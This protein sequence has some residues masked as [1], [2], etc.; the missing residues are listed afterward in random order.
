MKAFELESFGT[1]NL[2]L[3][4]RP[5]PEPGPQEVRVRMRA[6]SL[7]FRDLLMVRGHYNPRQPLPLVPLSDGV[8]LVE[9]VGEEVTRVAIGDRVAGIFAQTWLHAPPSHDHV[10]STLGGPLD[11]M[12]AEQVVLHQDGL[13]SLPDHLSDLEAATLP[14]AGVTAWNSLRGEGSISKGDTVLILGTGGVSIF[15]LLFARSLGA[16]T[17]VTSSSDA[18]LERAVELGASETINYKKIEQWW[19][20]VRELTNGQGVDHV[21]EVGGAGTFDQS[22][23]ATKTGGHVSLIG[24]LA[25]GAQKLDVTRILMNNIRVQGVLVGCRDVFEAMNKYVAT[26]ELHPV[27]DRVFPFAEL[28]KALDELGA[29]RHFGKIAIEFP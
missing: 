25:G 27:I 9:A 2:T 5:T 6:A 17:I 29:G 20:R 1:E 24:V 14:C 10:R 19:R 7:N 12:A 26:H 15:A 28:P 3:V 22:V 18:K 8:G 21:V 4:E 23:R 13:V 11:G 16:R